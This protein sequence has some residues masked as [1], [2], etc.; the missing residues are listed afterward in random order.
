MNLSEDLTPEEIV[1]V[2]ASLKEI[3]EG[4]CKTFNTVEEF[5]ADLHKR[6]SKSK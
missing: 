6:R 1:D 3:K 2:E 4:K 5:L